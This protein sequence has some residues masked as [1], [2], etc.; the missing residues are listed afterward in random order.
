M[1]VL[2]AIST[3]ST[4]VLQGIGRMKEPVIN[5]AIS[6][7]IHVIV[8]VVLL[9]QFRLNIYGV[10]YANTLFAFIIC[11]LNGLCIKRHLRYRQELRKTFLIPLLA[12][13]VMGVGAYLIY[14]AINSLM[15]IL[16]VDWASNMVA[17]LIAI[18]AGAAIYVFLLIKLRGI[19]ESEIANLPKGELMVRILRKIHFL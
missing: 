19:R 5:T 10:V 9:K 14:Y 7:V 1:I 15:N 18:L 16:F 4:A 13:A 2:F 3:L 11:I 12:S 17:T 6:L 8:L